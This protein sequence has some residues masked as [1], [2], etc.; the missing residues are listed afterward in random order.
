MS[1]T[2]AI[3]IWLWIVAAMILAMVV[4]GGATRLTE[5]GLSITEWKPISGVV[6]P[7]SEADWQAEFARYR[8]IPQYAQM[9]PDMTLGGFK[10]IFWWEWGHRLLGRLIGLVVALPLAAFWI[11]GKLSRDMKW[12]MLGLL[13][14]GGLQGFIGWWMVKSGLTER[15]EVS[16]YRLAV[17]LVTASLTLALTVWFAESLSPP[18]PS[19]RQG[20][21]GLRLAA[22]LLL[23]GV[24]VQ[25]GLGALVAGLRAGKIY[26]TWPLMG[27]HLVPPT[28]EL[29]FAHPLWRNVFENAT[30]AQFDHRAMAYLLLVAA[31]ANA[32]Y[33][34]RVAPGHIASRTAVVLAVALLCQAS[35]GVVTLVSGVQL[36]AALLHQ[37]FAMI[38]LAVAVTHRCSLRGIAGRDRLGAVPASE[39]G[40]EIIGLP[41]FAAGAR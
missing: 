1:A 13:A 8:A 14:L 32:I 17:H 15:T 38:V 6:P 33:A 2:T 27:N 31:A 35:I 21:R 11:G 25:L 16:Q 10:A 24:F 12:K 3:R 23:G 30:T 37:A 29:L 9:F 26:D 20:A 19:P 5:A 22:S 40:A 7:L 39:P 18:A 34:V 28:G 41:G 4:V 36:H